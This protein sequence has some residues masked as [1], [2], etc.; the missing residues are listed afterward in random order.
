MKKYK[1]SKNSDVDVSVIIVTRNRPEKLINCLQALRKN[2]FPSFE[3]V[4]ID[5]S[6]CE[7][8]N[9]EILVLLSAFSHTTYIHSK[10]KGKS[11]GLNQA[12]RLAKAP[13]L[14][15]TD[16]DCIPSVE[17]ISEIYN[18]FTAHPT[19]YSICGKTLPHKPQKHPGM[20]CPSTFQSDIPFTH[21]IKTP[22][23]HWKSIGLGNNMAF[24]KNVL[25][26]MG[27]FIEWLGPGS[28]G[29]NAEDAHMLLR[30]L[31]TGKYIL[32]NDKAIV[33]HDRWL[34][35]KQH[36]LQ[37]LEYECGEF[38]CYGIFALYG[39]PFAKEILK[40]YRGVILSEIREITKNAIYFRYC[41][42]PL[43]FWFTANMIA[44]MRGFIVA[45]LLVQHY[46]NSN[47]YW[48]E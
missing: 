33:Y 16:D 10:I 4:I 48:I 3:L 6:D 11:K 31:I 8:I 7:N 22:G 20:Y 14:A 1:H 41:S 35:E 39:Y 26:Q 18:G 37:N 17:W 36:K 34:T 44:R 19:V 12:I 28:I 43:F 25:I 38:A 47:Y 13:F 5:Q 21:L 30:V 9:H 42:I 27:G 15:F 2:S 46:K 45:F 24:R 23:I 32:Y 29:I 40:S